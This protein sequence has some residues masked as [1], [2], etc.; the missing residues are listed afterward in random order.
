MKKIINIFLII[1]SIVL[2]Q[3]CEDEQFESSLNYVTFGDTTYSAGVDVAGSTTIDVTV[4]TSKIVSSDVTFNVVVDPSSNAAAG[5]YEVPSSVTVL[6]GTNK[7]EMTI[8][9]SDVNLGIGV[10]KL[11]L[12]FDSVTTGYD[13]GGSTTVEYIQNCT[14]V[15]A[16]LDL[17]FDRWGSEVS[18]NIKDAL[19]GVVESGGGYSDT[20]SGTSTSDTITFTLCAGRTYTLT[21]TD[22]YGDGW[23]SVGNYTLTVG[24]VVK[25]TGDGSLMDNGGT[26]S[27]SATANFNTN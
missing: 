27:I 15:N 13:N 21:T 3:N 8:G 12:K 2:L 20:G 22:A 26:G 14:E 9:L 16:T 17:T 25:V 7:G 19:G 11:I 24:G 10:N 5:S 4:Y 23:G 1:F 6:S 18:W